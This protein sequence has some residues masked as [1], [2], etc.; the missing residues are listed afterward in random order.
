MI[1]SLTL[2]TPLIMLL[3]CKFI[4]ITIIITPYLQRL[5]KQNKSDT[6]TTQVHQIKLF[7]LCEDFPS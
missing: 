5:Q 2:I 6:K 1:L 4:K 3:Q 7:N